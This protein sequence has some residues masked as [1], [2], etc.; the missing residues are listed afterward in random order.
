[1]ADEQTTA[2]AETEVVDDEFVEWADENGNRCRGSR[3]GSAYKDFVLKWL[4]AEADHKAVTGLPVTEP[5]QAPQSEPIADA[6]AALTVDTPAPAVVESAT[7]GAT[8]SEETVKTVD[9]E[10]RRRGRR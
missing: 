2:P 1:M 7:E 8:D 9:A 4:T 10:S 5:A 3:Y 6:A